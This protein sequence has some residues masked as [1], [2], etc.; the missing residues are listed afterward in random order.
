MS[1]IT[2]TPDFNTFS[3]RTCDSNGDNCSEYTAINCDNYSTPYIPTTTN[4]ASPVQ[5]QVSVPTSTKITNCDGKNVTSNGANYRKVFT[6]TL[7]GS[8]SYDM[9]TTENSYTANFSNKSGTTVG[10]NTYTGIC[11]LNLN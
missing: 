11:T 2:F 4:N 10:E 5:L 3:V 8:K 6:C 9:T 7:D 1:S